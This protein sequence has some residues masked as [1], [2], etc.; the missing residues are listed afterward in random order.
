MFPD[1]FPDVFPDVFPD[2]FPD[3]FPNVFPDLFPDLFPDCLI[4]QPFPSHR[5]IINSH[6]I[7]STYVYPFGVVSL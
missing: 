7:P 3:V 2:L 4:S 6:P 1:L 5:E